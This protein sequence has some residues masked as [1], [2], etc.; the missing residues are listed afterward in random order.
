MQPK[1]GKKAETSLLKN[2]GCMY[3]TMLLAHSGSQRES[4]LNRPPKFEE[5]ASADL[6]QPHGFGSPTKAEKPLAA[7]LSHSRIPQP[8]Y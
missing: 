3:V 8:H 7:A 5:Q 1:R 4:P 2:S 6:A